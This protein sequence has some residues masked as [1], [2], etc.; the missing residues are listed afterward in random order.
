M[1]NCYRPVVLAVKLWCNFRI[2]HSPLPFRTFYHLDKAGY[3]FIYFT[4]L[5]WLW[6][7]CFLDLSFGASLHG[8]RQQPDLCL[9]IWEH[10]NCSPRCFSHLQRYRSSVCFQSPQCSFS[11]TFNWGRDASAKHFKHQ[12]HR[13]MQATSLFISKSHKKYPTHPLSVPPS[14]MPAIIPSWQQQ[15]TTNVMLSCAET[16]RASWSWRTKC[17]LFL[18]SVQLEVN[19]TIKAKNF[20][21]K[22]CA[23]GDDMQEPNEA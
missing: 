10:H 18:S 11:S 21:T 8:K 14:M 20:S 16:N 2:L 3:L 19:G 5:L 9:C 1:Q 15:S 23:L 4:H 12:L 22:L 6:R 7:K 13:C 17:L